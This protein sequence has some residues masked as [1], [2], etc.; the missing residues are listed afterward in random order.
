MAPD[1]PLALKNGRHPI[2]EAGFDTVVQNM[3]DG[4]RKQKAG[5]PA[6]G[7]LTYGGLEKPEGADAPGHKITR[8]LPGGETWV[9]YLDPK[10][11]LPTF[12]QETGPGGE[13]LE[14][15]VFRDL[16]PNVAELAK[17]EAFDPDARWGPQKGLF[18]RLARSPGGD[19][20]TKTR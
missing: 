12:V 7:K 17:A 5:D 15:Y 4:L 8:V 19:D 18:Q 11:M 2:T 1:S 13:L 20:G 9:V 10:S 16:T 6:G 14:R 3:A